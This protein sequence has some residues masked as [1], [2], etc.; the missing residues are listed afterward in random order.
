MF[1]ML[2]L[3]AFN[4]KINNVEIDSHQKK[5]EWAMKKVFDRVFNGMKISSKW[6][7]SI[8]KNPIIKIR[9]LLIDSN[10]GHKISWRPVLSETNKHNKK[11]KNSSSEKSPTE[12]KKRSVLRPN[13]LHQKMKVGGDQRRSSPPVTERKAYWR[14]C[15]SERLE[16][17]GLEREPFTWF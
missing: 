6:K 2:H 15:S 10:Q 12:R 8:N 11:E 14:N 4:G 3:I 1:E 5:S 16:E 7:A 17:K 9:W 13:I